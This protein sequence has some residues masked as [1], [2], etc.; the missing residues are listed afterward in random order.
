MSQSSSVYVSGEF[1]EPMT[2]QHNFAN[3]Y[4]L[5]NPN[6]AMSVYARYV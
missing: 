5:D 3:Q 4:D 2:A 1:S 6:Q